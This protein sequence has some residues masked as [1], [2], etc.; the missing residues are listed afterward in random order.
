MHEIAINYL[1]VV[2]AA[3]AKIVLG[4][5]WYSPVAFVRPWMEMVGVT[6]AQM[7]TRMP[8]ALAV[9]VIGSLIMAFVLAHAV[10]YAGAATIATGAAV[11]FFNWLGLVAIATIAS[12]TYEGRPLRYFLINNGY[13]LLSLVIMGAIL[14]VWR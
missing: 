13:L 8:T 11:G 6:D 2:A 4:A 14:A 5:V 3:L 7:K 9:D 12:V 10:G 1:A